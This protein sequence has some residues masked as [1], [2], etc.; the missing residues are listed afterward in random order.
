[1]R[2]VS[3][4]S[5]NSA[6]FQMDVG[7]VP[8]DRYRSPVNADLLWG[9]AVDFGDVD[10]WRHEPECFVKDAANHAVVEVAHVDLV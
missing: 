2:V 7:V 8:R 6:A 1:M 4:A 3:R 9:S 10:D 5:M